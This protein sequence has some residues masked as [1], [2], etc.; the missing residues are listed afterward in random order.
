MGIP[1]TDFFSGSLL[2]ILQ[3]VCKLKKNIPAFLLTAL[4]LSTTFS[5]YAQETEVPSEKSSQEKKDEVQDEESQDEVLSPKKE[6]FWEPGIKINLDSANLRLGED[7]ALAHG[8][9]LTLGYSQFFPNDFILR[10][11]IGFGYSTYAGYPGFLTA[12][13]STGAHILEWKN[14]QLNA[15][16]S[17][18]FQTYCYK[19]PFWGFGPDLYAQYP[20]ND[21]FLIFADLGIRYDFSFKSFWLATSA[22]LSIRGD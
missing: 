10:W 18:D 9:Y 21:R 2:L 11:N 12:T 6:N 4:L 22:G 19:I 13:V 14:I 16:F 17:I 3:G 15:L 5:L 8:Y 20:I 7:P 1:K